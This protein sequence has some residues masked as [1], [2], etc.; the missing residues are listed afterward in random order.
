MPHKLNMRI[1]SRLREMGELLE[2]QGDTGFRSKAY[3]RAAAVVE[4]LGRPVDEILAEEGREGLMA[5]PAVGYGIASA[6]AE[7]VSNG[8]WAALDRLAGRL[9]PE[10]L[11]MTVPG[12]GRQLARRAHR[13]LHIDTLEELEEAATDGRLA[14]L[15][16]VGPRRAEAIRAC[17]ED[18]LKLIRGH[19]RPRRMP[20]IAVLLEVDAEY[21][22]K[23]ERNEL[24]LI[25][26]RRFNPNR[27]PWLPVMHMHRPPW[28]YT[29]MFSN[30]AR[31]HHLNKCRDWVVIF[32]ARDNAPDWQCTVV[33]ERRG[34]LKGKRIVRG[35]E[36][37]S[38]AFYR[39]P[40][41]A[42]S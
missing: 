27:I 40:A 20:D 23:A 7:M 13:D 18:R 17:L 9:D 1:A 25:A 4:Q 15:A 24:K 39:S 35:L 38:E 8:S 34:A 14:Q 31:A 37:E 30:T 26:P 2:H 16:G 3:L 5:L 12:V 22:R 28:H 33:T 29:A 19:V 11:F 41:G 42:A 21:R 10:T 36:A 32:V 6:I